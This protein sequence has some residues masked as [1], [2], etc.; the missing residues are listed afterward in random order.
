VSVRVHS[1]YDRRL[2]DTAVAGREVLIRLRVRRWFCG[3]PECARRTFTEQVSGLAARYAR[4]TAILQRVLCAVGLALGGRAGARLTRV[5]AASVSR[6]TLLRLVRGLPDP[7]RPTP[8][9][10]GVDDF[11]LRRGHHYGTVLVDVQT[12]R[13]VDVLPDR[14][15]ATLAD[16]LRTHPGVQI[17]C[18]DRASAYA[19]GAREG[20]P[21]AVQ[22]A[23]RWHVWNN[24]AG[25][26]ERTVARHQGCLIAAVAVGSTTTDA[27]DAAQHDVGPDEPRPALPGGPD[28]R[29]DRWAVRARERH[30]AVHALLTDGVGITEICRRLGLARGT[31]RRFAPPTRCRSC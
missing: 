10:L 12:R 11:A 5:L 4:R 8:R 3:N 30:A 22:V 19:E 6:M 13:P 14:T 15:A 26:V 23:D 7:D 24:L 25:A 18:R 16:W 31:V 2:S 9:V 21:D 17:V 29:T 1:R 28:E 27:A 20:A